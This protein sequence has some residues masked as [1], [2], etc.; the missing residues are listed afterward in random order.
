MSAILLIRSAL[1]A[2]TAIAF[3]PS[4]PTMPSAANSAAIMYRLAFFA[5]KKLERN[6]NESDLVVFFS[7]ILL[8][9][10]HAFFGF[11]DAQQQFDSRI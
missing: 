5:K 4:G 3:K 7:S 1:P 2:I 11:T 8:C 6:A 10:I 9:F